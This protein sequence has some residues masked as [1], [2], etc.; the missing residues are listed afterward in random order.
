MRATFSVKVFHKSRVFVRLVRRFLRTTF[1]VFN[2][3][4]NHSNNINRNTLMEEIFEE[5]FLP[6][7]TFLQNF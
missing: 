7:R 1:S 4:K 6:G 3:S 5:E 2:V